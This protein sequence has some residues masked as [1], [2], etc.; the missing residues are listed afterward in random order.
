M[1]P[2]CK[3]MSCKHY[4]VYPRDD[5]RGCPYCEAFPKGIPSKIWWEEIEHTA[6]YPG[7]H[8]IQYEPAQSEHDMPGGEVN[9]HD[10]KDLQNHR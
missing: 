3:C 1:F 2:V 8:G 6:P 4:V 7:D 10:G 5:M 9:C